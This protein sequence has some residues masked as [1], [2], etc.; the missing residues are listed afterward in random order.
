M[1]MSNINIY[2]VLP[3][4]SSLG[5]GMCPQDQWERLTKGLW[6]KPMSPFDHKILD[7]RMAV[8]HSE[9]LQVSIDEGLFY[10]L[11]ILVF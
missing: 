11:F 4:N 1:G 6:T 9:I 2:S 7:I 10:Y 8:S 5:I 3:R